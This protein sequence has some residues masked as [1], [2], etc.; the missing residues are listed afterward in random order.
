MANN[1]PNRN[2]PSYET[3][4]EKIRRLEKSLQDRNL[5]LRKLR[6]D[7]TQQSTT[8]L[9]LRMNEIQEYNTSTVSM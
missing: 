9:R 6:N 7:N 1:I 3:Q 2:N 8:L 4:Q 5:E